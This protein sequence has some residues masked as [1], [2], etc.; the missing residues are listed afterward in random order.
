MIRIGHG[1]DVHKFGGEGPVII[2]GVA[3][4]MSKV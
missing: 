1:F 2:G 3:I 4:L